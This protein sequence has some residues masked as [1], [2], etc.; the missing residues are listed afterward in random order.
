MT[1]VCVRQID[2]PKCDLVLA[3][4]DLIVYDDGYVWQSDLTK[5]GLVLAHY[6]GHVGCHRV[7]TVVYIWQIDLPKCDLV[8][9][10]HDDTAVYDDSSK[11]QQEF[12]DD[13]R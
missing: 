6:G 11:A 13:P 12:K 9:A 3:H 8:L 4:H 2:V 5:C 7:M 1:V 10:H